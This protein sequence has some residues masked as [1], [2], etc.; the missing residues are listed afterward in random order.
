MVNVHSKYLWNPASTEHIDMNTFT[1]RYQIELKFHEQTYHLTWVIWY[2]STKEDISVYK[3]KQNE[4][5]KTVWEMLFSV[6]NLYSTT[7][8][9]VTS[10]QNSL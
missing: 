2:D 3:E 10:V 9:M 6:V 1:E 8:N 4:Y 5:N 7:V